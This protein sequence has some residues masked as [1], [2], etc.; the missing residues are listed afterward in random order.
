MKALIEKLA[1]GNAVFETPD[2]EISENRIAVELEQGENWRGEISIKGKHGMPV[3][4]I[5]FS[6]DN[7][8]SFENNQFY[9]IHNTVKYVVSSRNMLEG[10]IISGTI[11]IITTAGD[12]AIP[13]AITIKKKEIN[14]S[15]GNITD[16]KG[17]VRLVKNS[18][19]EALILFL[20][21]EFKD[22]FLRT[23]IA[24]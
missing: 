14:S 18:Y 10:Q 22:F 23:K 5:V 3:K 11:S 7:H 2:A 6:T 15:I 8:V 12:Y 24:R 16:L 20:S 13:F 9:G 17:F 4:G 19:D 1:S 21:K